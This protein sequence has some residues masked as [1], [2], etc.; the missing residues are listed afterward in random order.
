MQE[1]VRKHEKQVKSKKAKVKTVRTAGSTKKTTAPIG[2]NYRCNWCGVGRPRWKMLTIMKFLR[3]CE[4]F[5]LLVVGWLYKLSSF[6]TAARPLK[7]K[8]SG[9]GLPWLLSKSGSCRLTCFFLI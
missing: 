5:G 7:P 9:G 1:M 6:F 4:I 3:F 8:F 2:F